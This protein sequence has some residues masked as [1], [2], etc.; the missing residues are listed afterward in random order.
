MAV[1][2]LTILS[3]ILSLFLIS[4]VVSQHLIFELKD[5]QYQEIIFWGDVTVAMICEITDVTQAEVTIS[6]DGVLVAT[7]NGEGNCLEFVISRIDLTDNVNITCF[8]SYN[9]DV[10][11]TTVT[12][13]KTLML[14]VS[15]IDHFCFRNGT[16]INQPY[17]VGDVLLLSCYCRATEPCVWTDT[18][19]GTEIGRVIKPIEEKTYN[20]KKIRRIIVGPFNDTHINVSRYDCSHGPTVDSR[21]SIGPFGDFAGDF[22]LNPTDPSEMSLK[23]SVIEV[24][25]KRDDSP[26]TERISTASSRILSSESVHVSDISTISSEE[27]NSSITYVLVIAIVTCFVVVM[28]VVCTVIVHARMHRKERHTRRE[29]SEDNSRQYDRTIFSVSNT[30]Y[31]PDYMYVH[32]EE[33]NRTKDS[34]PTYES[35]I[36]Q[37]PSTDKCTTYEETRHVYLGTDF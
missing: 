35:K 18:I 34:A 31:T 4:P 7:N 21:C 33:S 2:S 36:H 22:I 8:A 26:T 12:D 16:G 15:G 32:E 19:L 10:N 23:C 20:N 6:V 17:Q 3:A 24:F 30:N 37:Q 1:T 29:F 28:L 25:D 13:T 11:M 14:N 9:K 27:E 5:K